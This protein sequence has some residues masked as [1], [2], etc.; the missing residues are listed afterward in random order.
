MNIEKFLHLINAQVYDGL[1]GLDRQEVVGSLVRNF[2][3]DWRKQ[4]RKVVTIFLKKMIEIDA[5]DIDF[6]GRGCGN[7]VWLRVHGQK[8]PFEELGQYTLEHSDILIQNLLSEKQRDYLFLKRNLD[9]SYEIGKGGE[10]YRFRA[11][12]YFDLDNL[13][14]NMRYIPNEIRSF[15]D[16]NLHHEVA[17]VLNLETNKHGL[18]LITGITGS[19]KSST[20]DSIVD[21]N[22]NSINAHIVIIGAP[23]ETVHKPIKCLIRHREVGRDVLSFKEGAVHSLRQD[24]DIIIIGEMRDPDTIITTLEITD[25]GHKVFSTLHTASAVE[26]IDRILGE[27]PPA[28]QERVRMRLADTLNCIISQKLVPD[29]KGTRTLAKEV[30]IVTSSIRAAI[31]NGNISEIYQMIFEGSDLGMHTMEQDLLRKVRTGL[32]SGETA[33]HFANNK[34]R[35]SELIGNR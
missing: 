28:E 19:G 12:V 22:N 15:K 1:K 34:K 4:L 8:D 18:T 27:T 11:N 23:I 31:R 26:S 20:L 32:I 25:S 6:G 5:S 21:A 29:L 24:P 2:T 13:A 3:D 16:L 7:R 9:F 35:M 17:N 10:R 14:I 30:M 33:M